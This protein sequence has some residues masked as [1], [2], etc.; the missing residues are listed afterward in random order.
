MLL[1]L[2]LSVL[3]R[4]SALLVKLP[5]LGVCGRFSEVGL[6]GEEAY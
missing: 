1:R 2:F 5:P 6:S 4:P 3:G